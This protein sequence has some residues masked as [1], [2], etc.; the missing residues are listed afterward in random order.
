MNAANAVSV[1]SVVVEY[2][3]PVG[4]VRALNGLSLILDGGTSVA[5]TGPSGGGKSTLLGL[6]GGLARPTAGAVRIGGQ[7]I[8]LL[9]ET[10]RSNFRRSHIGCVY[11][12]DNLL[13]FL[14]VLENVQLPLALVG[15]YADVDR[16]LQLLDRLDLAGLAHRLPDQ[17]SGGQR[18]RV[19]VA[20]AVVHRPT[21]ILADEPTGALDTRNAAGVIEVLLDMQAD[22]GATLVMVTHDVAAASRLDEQL[23]LANGRLT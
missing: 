15:Q 10:D 2:A 9:S 1:E 7:E 16:S 8:S 13:P 17:L 14:T 18:Q 11:Q 4:A 20:R 6:L 22:L 23:E 3:T 12:A 5:I 21:V 19:A